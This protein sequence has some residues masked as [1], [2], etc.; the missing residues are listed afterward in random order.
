[1]NG[2]AGVYSETVLTGLDNL[3][4]RLP[5]AQAAALD[6]RSEA[7]AWFAI[8]SPDGAGV[9]ARAHT[10]AHD[11]ERPLPGH[12]AAA[13]LAALQAMMPPGLTSDPAQE[14]DRGLFCCC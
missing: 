2:I 6:N 1:M 11:G 4:P 5:P 14:S 7:V 13:D 12:L 3:A 8:P 10:E 9:I